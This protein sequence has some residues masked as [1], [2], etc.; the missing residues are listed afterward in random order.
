M[1][2]TNA[3]MVGNASPWRVL[4]K[5]SATRSAAFSLER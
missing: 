3:D 2:D 1:K 4:P 5:L